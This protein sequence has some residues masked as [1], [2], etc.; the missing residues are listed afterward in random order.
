MKQALKVLA[1]VLVLA[2]AT[3]AQSLPA[4]TH[5]TVRLGSALSSATA[6]PG[7]AW[8]GTLARDIIVN[9]RTIAKAGTPVRGT[10]VS[11]K[12]SGR[13][14][15]PGVLSLRLTSISVNG[16]PTAIR[17]AA[18]TRQGE[19]HKKSN[20]TKIGGGAAAGAVIGAIAG[21]GKGAAIGTMA[22]G[23]AGTGAAAYTGRKDVVLPAESALS[24]T[25][26]RTSSFG[27]NAGRK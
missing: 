4:G 21:G 5:V 26:V 10:V 23:A 22:G 13:L 6:K 12:P 9:G 11:A 27:R 18:V 7:E 20:A 2:L 19:S 1:A 8:V 15:D 3:W 14:K 25:V 16:T 24:F 17:T